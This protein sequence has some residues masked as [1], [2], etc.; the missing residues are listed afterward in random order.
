MRLRESNESSTH[1][2]PKLSRLADVAA[3]LVVL[4]LSIPSLI[5]FGKSWAIT[6]DATEYLL[7][8]WHLVTGEGY[9]LTNDIP[10]TKRGPVLP[11]LIGFLTFP[12]VR[13]TET[14]AWAVRLL[15][16]VN[17]LLGYF[18]VKR[19]SGPVAG[20]LAA[21]LLALFSYIAI[22]PDPF[23]IDALLVMVFLS[24]LL[25][26]LAAAQRNSPRLA[27]FS[28][29][30]IG[31]AIITKETAVASLPLAALAGLFAG[32]SLRGV[33]LHY[34][35]VLLVC[36]PWWAWVFAVSGEVYLVGRMPPGLHLPAIA[37]VLV[38]AGLTATLYLSGLPARLLASERR[39]RWIGWILS[40][41]W[42]AAMSAMLLTTSTKI[43]GAS[44]QT[45][46]RYVTGPLARDIAIWPLVL[47]AAGYL[48]WK[49]AQRHPNWQLF[50]A[51]AL[52]QVPACLL[53]TVEGW[54]R[55]QFILLQALLLCALAALVVET[56][57]AT[58]HRQVLLRWLAAAATAFLAVFLLVSAGTEAR[59]ML[60]G[61]ST[62][63]VAGSKDRGSSEMVAWVDENMPEGGTI[64][65]P[66]GQVGYLTFLDG[67][68]RKWR[69]HGYDRTVCRANSTDPGGVCGDDRGSTSRPLPESTVWLQIESGCET[70]ALSS[71]GL[72][73]RMDRA[74]AD[75]L[76]MTAFKSN[77]QLLGLAERMGKEPAFETVF[78]GEMPDSGAG[79]IQEPVLLERTGRKAVDMPVQ[80]NAHTALLLAQCE[81]LEG[82]EARQRIR[83]ELP[84]GIEITPLPEGT[85]SKEEIESLAQDVVDS[86]Y[87]RGN[88]EVAD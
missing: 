51:A 74:G 70:T 46:A 37:G 86:I 69:S 40:F 66:P 9:T 21:A 10:F 68:Q 1:A 2:S 15:A 5:W 8:G 73:R 34:L 62:K 6:F 83:N 41:A 65:A 87:S 77:S 78:K 52:F 39:R 35:V 47:L 36:L 49:A 45:V 32:L 60:L 31:L 25:A 24:A 72:L 16:T 19:I 64:F 20:L 18:L 57:T 88:G 85:V 80:M 53:V 82:S 7:S 43:A 81:G 79:M 30:L 13:D 67:G 44:F 22:N 54:D 3:I 12:F 48:L 50:A 75:Y 4:V 59:S 14:L 58:A 26:L 63:T 33:V 29:L 55:R 84:N 28:G 11:A 38:V 56:A 61:E 27:L 17:P 71:S 42:V 23:N 76:M